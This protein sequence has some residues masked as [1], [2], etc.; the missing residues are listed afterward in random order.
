MTIITSSAANTSSNWFAYSLANTGRF[1]TSYR[2][3]VTNVQT[4]NSM[5]FKLTRPSGMTGSV[6]VK[7]Y[8]AKYNNPFYYPSSNGGTSITSDFSNPLATSADINIETL[9]VKISGLTSASDN[10]TFI[11][12]STTIG[13]ASQI[14]NYCAVVEVINDNIITSNLGS[15][16]VYVWESNVPGATNQ[17]Q[18]N[19]STNSYASNSGWEPY[20]T[21]QTL[22]LNTAPTN[23]TLSSSSISESAAS[24][25][26]VGTLSA[27]DAE[28]GAMTFSLVSGVGSTDNASFSI[29]GNALQTAVS[30]NY[31]AKSSYSVR[32]RATD[33][34]A[35]SFEK[36]FTISVTNANEA[37]TSISLSSNSIQ[38]GNQLNAVIGTLSA[39]DADVSDSV[40]FSIVSG[41]DKF[42]I[43]GAQ[44]RASVVFDRETASSHLVTVRATDAGGLSLDQ[45]FSISVSNAG[46][47][48]ISLSSTSISESA[49]SQATVGMLSAVDPGGGSCLF[50]LVSGAGSED[51]A[52]FQISGTDL[53]LANGVSLDY[54]AKTN[55]SVRIQAA[56]ADGATVEQS[57]AISV[58]N[59]TSDDPVSLPNSGVPTL[60][61]GQVVVALSANPTIIPVTINSQM[62][63]TGSVVRNTLTGQKFVKIDGT[64]LDYIAIE[65]EPRA[66][67]DWS[68]EG[69]DAWED[70]QL[71]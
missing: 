66:A 28:G 52:S 33:S 3:S 41:G 39:I 62:L 22:A 43:S 45:S 63:P 16:G 34:S 5:V 67:W 61:S 42:N 50:S 17:L 18:Y 21:L 12:P 27:T 68:Q 35:L 20:F 32:V 29:V 51:N 7:L 57:F 47:V 55:Y 65:V 30:L 38:E 59:N 15:R 25:S 46:P 71:M 58:L 48:S 6:R 64:Q 49:S 11:F 36:A 70:L 1:K 23:I 8:D 54:E 19:L 13:T 60:A 26:S 31:E 53:K 37:P 10:I 4:F 44:L 9:A 69:Q 2:F 40:S 24:G 56:D 14:K